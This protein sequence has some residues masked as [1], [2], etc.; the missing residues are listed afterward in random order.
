MKKFVLPVLALC[1]LAA[2]AGCAAAPAPSLPAPGGAASSASAGSSAPSGEVPG[3][4]P[5]DPEE[6]RLLGLAQEA[7]GR[8]MTCHLYLDM[9]RDGAAELLG[10][11]LNPDTDLYE[12]WYCSSDGQTC[13]LA[14]QDE[15]SMESCF[16][17]PLTLDGEIHVAVN[18]GLG[19]NSNRFS[20]LALQEGK[21]NCLVRWQPGMVTMT[22]AGD[23]LVKTFSL[24]AFYDTA[25]GGTIGLGE[26]QSYLFY[27]DG[28]YGEYGA[29]ELT[30]EEFN[31]LQGAQDLM[32]GIEHALRFKDAERMECRYFL[33]ANGILQVQCDLHAAEGGVE[34]GFFTARCQ[35]GAVDPASMGSFVNGQ[36]ESPLTSLEVV[37]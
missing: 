36:L 18:R 24:N 30:E 35:D 23:L 5:E 25:V 1:L 12:V 22:D 2:L 28:T 29:V 31:A 14:A 37:Y 34:Y 13:T 26:T 3:P 10:V 9:D 16:L 33:R 21:I 11:C 27:R 20:I 7:S 4:T 19:N 8:E 17:E 6:A 15:E 32:A